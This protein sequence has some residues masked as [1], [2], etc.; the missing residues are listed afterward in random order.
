MLKREKSKTKKETFI[1]LLAQLSKSKS[2]DKGK[3]K[4][5]GK[6]SFLYIIK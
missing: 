4:S 5:K 6:G 3:S 2:K 1:K